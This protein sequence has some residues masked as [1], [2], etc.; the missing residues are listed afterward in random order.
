MEKWLDLNFS[1]SLRVFNINFYGLFIFD[2]KTSRAM[3]KIFYNLNAFWGYYDYL[4]SAE[5]S[6]TARL[7]VE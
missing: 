6:V 2:E 7:S 3:F 5:S 1:N 4:Y